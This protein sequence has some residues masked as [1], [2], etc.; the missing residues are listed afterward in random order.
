MWCILLLLLTL[1]VRGI[2]K[3]SPNNLCYQWGD[4]KQRTVPCLSCIHA[5]I[6]Y[7][8]FVIFQDPLLFLSRNLSIALF[9]Q[10]KNNFFN[11]IH[12]FSKR[13][14]INI[15]EFLL[16]FCPTFPNKSISS[17]KIKYIF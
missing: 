14:F 17:N 10:F 4:A 7:Y 1:A 3:S 13:Y 9:N 15:I 11:F 16:I 8:L 6:F 12:Y 5:K 2:S